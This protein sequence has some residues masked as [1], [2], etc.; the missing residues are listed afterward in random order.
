VIRVEPDT[1][2]LVRIR[3]SY[4]PMW[5]LG[6][7]PQQQGQ[8]QRASRVNQARHDDGPPDGTVAG[9]IGVRL[10]ANPHSAV[11][12]GAALAEGLAAGRPGLEGEGGPQFQ[13]CVGP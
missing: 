3:P 6:H 2:A 10:Q 5:K 11:T 1:E 9:A 12:G 13:P 4:S 7:H 8:C